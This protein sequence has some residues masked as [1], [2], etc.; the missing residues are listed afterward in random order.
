MTPVAQRVRW[1]QF[2]PYVNNGFDEYMSW[3]HGLIVKL[4]KRLSQEPLV[5]RELHLVEDPG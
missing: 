1:P 5:S 2:A 3:Y 4:E